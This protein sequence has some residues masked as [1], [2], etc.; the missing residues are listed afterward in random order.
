MEQISYTEGKQELLLQHVYCYYDVDEDED[1]DYDVL[2][3]YSC[4]FRSFGRG[5]LTIMQEKANKQ[6]DNPVSYLAEMCRKNGVPPKD[7]GQ[8]RTIKEWFA[9]KQSLK[10]QIS[11]ADHEDSMERSLVHPERRQRPDSAKDNRLRMYAIAFALELTGAETERLFT[12]VYL[13]RPFDPR[14]AEEFVFRFCIDRGKRYKDAINIIERLDQTVV[15]LHR[16]KGENCVADRERYGV[17]GTLENSN[18]IL[19]EAVEQSSSVAMHKRLGDFRDEDELVDYINTHRGAFAQNNRTATCIIEHY[20]RKL[21]ARIAR[22]AINWHDELEEEWKAKKEKL[23]REEDY[24]VKDEHKWLTMRPFATKRKSF[25]EALHI[26]ANAN[27]KVRGIRLFEEYVS[28]WESFIEEDE[29]C[30]FVFDFLHKGLHHGDISD[31]GLISAILSY[32]DHGCEDEEI[33]VPIAPDLRKELRIIFQSPKILSKVRTRQASSAEIREVLIL[34]V[35]VEYWC[36]QPKRILY[37]PG[38]ENQWLED[39]CLVINAKLCE[40]NCSPLYYGNPYDWVYMFCAATD[41]PLYTFR[42][43]IGK[44]DRKQAENSSKEDNNAP[45]NK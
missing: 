2:K 23:K 39:F 45:N 25:F 9:S 3:Q 44:P 29:E 26:I 8:L 33:Y 31:A 7:I 30:E 34:F 35:A 37:E 10:S 38:E 41:N 13:D 1:I 42:R 19:G 16:K 14:I 32:P 21:H 18:T 28:A 15:S 27:Q 11:E 17:S 43:M 36:Q 22:E 6:I 5:L 12:K 40:A 24:F 20:G 4:E